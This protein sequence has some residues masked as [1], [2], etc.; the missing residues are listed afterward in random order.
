MFYLISCHGKPNKDSAT[1]AASSVNVI[2]CDGLLLVRFTLRAGNRTK[3]MNFDWSC[4]LISMAYRY[5]QNNPTN[6]HAFHET[7]SY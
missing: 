7:S 1:Y 3:Q 5:G 2:V 6:G 4:K